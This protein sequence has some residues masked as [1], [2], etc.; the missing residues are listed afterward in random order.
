MPEKVT[1]QEAS[2]RLNISQDL[3]R[4]YIRDGVLKAERGGGSQGRSW[5]VELPQDGWV[6][7]AKLSYMTL[8]KQLPTW[9]WPEPEKMG[10]VHYLE[11]TGI[12]ELVPV[13]LCGLVSENIWGAEG[14]LP[15][16]RCQEC[17]LE[18]QARGLS[19]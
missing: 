17:V 19:L 6:D 13:F 2:R 18:A 16:Q 1:I 8:D 14:H 9:W 4:R 3:V 10:F 15:Q 7:D 12:E 5:M 11:S